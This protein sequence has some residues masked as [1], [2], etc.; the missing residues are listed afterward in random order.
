MV[1]ETACLHFVSPAFDFIRRFL[2]VGLIKPFHDF[3]VACALLDLRLEI[4][5][6]HTFEAKEHVIEGDNRSDTRQYF[7]SPRRG[8]YRLCGQELRNRQREP[9]DCVALLS[10]DLF[11]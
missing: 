3:L 9:A 4:V 6:L 5:A 10:S 8:I 2:F 7:P 11:R 1:V